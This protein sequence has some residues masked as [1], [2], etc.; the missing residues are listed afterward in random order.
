M[1]HLPGVFFFVVVVAIRRRLSCIW[2]FS[3][4][5]PVFVAKINRR[6]RKQQ[7]LARLV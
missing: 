6:E 2:G 5:S 7:F 4:R 3:Q 1:C